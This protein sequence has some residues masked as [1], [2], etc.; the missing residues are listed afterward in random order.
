MS[1]SKVQVV[2]NVRHVFLGANFKGNG[3]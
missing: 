2:K 1:E 3:Q